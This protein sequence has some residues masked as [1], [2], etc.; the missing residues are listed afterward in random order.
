MKP[1]AVW[2]PGTAAGNQGILE[3]HVIKMCRPVK[4][5][6]ILVVA[7][8]AAV[9]PVAGNGMANG[10]QESGPETRRISEEAEAASARLRQEH[11]PPAKIP[12]ETELRFRAGVA[13]VDI[14]PERPM[15]LDGYWSDRLST[16]V[17]APLKVKALVLDDGRTRIALVISDLITYYFEWGEE[18][19]RKQSAV[20]PEN[21]VLCTTHTHAAPLM[22]GVF[23]EIYMDYVVWTGE[24]MAEAITRA[25]DTL[26]PARI[27]FAAGSLPEE[28]GTLKGVAQNWHN[29]GVIDDTLLVMRVENLEGD[30]IATLV[31]FGN[32]PD[33]LG[34]ETTL[35]SPDFFW[36]VYEG[37][38][39]ALGGSTLVFNRALG[40]VEPIGQGA[41]DIAEAQ[42][43]MQRI[44]G[45][46]TETVVETA[47]SLTW[48]DEPRI[49]VRR[50]RCEFPILSP[51]ILK[52]FDA[53]LLPLKPEGGVQINEMALLEIGPAQIL[54]VPGEPHPEVVFKLVD[55]MK[56][57]YPFVFSQAEDGIGYVVPEGLFNPEGIQELLS[58]G[59]DNEF[60]VL[61]AAR[62][63]LGVDSYVE[64]EAVA[65]ND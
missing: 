19:K 1:E 31:N 58:T 30:P 40:G 5:L 3:M 38:T 16:G 39:D 23:G 20:A 57:S 22:V 29:P 15:R 47:E 21:V 27:G 56:P 50:T 48:V 60:V 12:L 59:R 6:A 18:A 53:G 55:M 63:L 54:T 35:V 52:A 10:E 61:C 26:E 45:I 11:A 65:E 51:E 62:R 24:R 32:H 36:Y 37:V 25:A 46:V 13:E 42:A 41:N 7:V 44:G 2:G 9:Y 17:H 28:D 8:F 33:V 34:N 43:I 49:T 64:P 4:E 14:T